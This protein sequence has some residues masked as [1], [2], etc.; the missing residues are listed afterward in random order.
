MTQDLQ[1]YRYSPDYAVPPGETLAEVLQERGMSQ[2]ELARRADISA[3]HVNQ[4]VQ[5]DAPISPEIALK[6]ERVTQVPAGLWTQ[7]EAQYQ[8][9]Q[10]AKAE[11]QTLEADVDWLPA[12][13]VKELVQRGWITRRGSKVD[14]LR[15]VLSFFGVAS[16]NAWQTIWDVPTAYRRS[17]AF[18]SDL[19]ALAAWLRIGELRA[20]QLECGPFHRHGFR[21]ALGEIR[22]LT[23]IDDPAT[24]LPKLRALCA[25]NGVA[26]V[27]E[28]EI[29]GARI[30]GA[31]RWLASD[32]VL[33]ELSLRH[34]WADIFWFSFFHEAAH[35]LLHERKRQTFIDATRTDGDDLELEADAFASRILIPRE[36]EKELETVRTAIQVRE[37]A[38]QIGIGAGIVVG[39]LQ[40]DKQLNHNQLNSLRRRFQF[41]ADA[42]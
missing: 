16:R 27:I 14:Q 28:K 35:I 4:I 12:L 30:N 13:P 26:V 24:W 1:H 39:R 29:P 19:H 3:K 31:V 41:R 18:E 2:A 7:L 33:L 37:F 6:L 9:Q 5:A 38:Q 32:L 10:S 11:A 23:R 34:R 42:R 40:H 25:A 8:Q 21:T 36:L 20:Q 17:R 15:E 22:E